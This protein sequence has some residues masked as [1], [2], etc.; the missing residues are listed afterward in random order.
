TYN[1]TVHAMTRISPFY[2][3]Y[4]MHPRMHLAPFVTSR[5]HLERSADDHVTKITELREQLQ[6]NILEAQER[7]TKY[8]GGKDMTF[9][10]GDK[11]WL[12]TRNIKTSRASK[13]LDYK[14][15]GPYTVTKVINK[16]AYKLNLP[17]TLRIHNVFHVSLLDAYKSPVTGQ[18]PPEPLPVISSDDPDSTEWEVERI[19][20]SRTRGRGPIRRIEYLV[21]WA[22]YA[23]IRTTW[24]P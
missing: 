13:K 4:G 23:Y 21:Q 3:M 12:S 9:N 15:I 14:R 16:N 7:Q 22:G 2:A 11:V 10:V 5:I 20:D 8:A 1:N 18:L 24:E 19:I 6:K 17:P